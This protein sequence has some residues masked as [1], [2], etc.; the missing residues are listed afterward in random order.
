MSEQPHSAPK[1][2]LFDKKS[3]HQGKTVPTDKTLDAARED[4]FPA[5][6]PP[7]ITPGGKSHDQPE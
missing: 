3:D 2:G 6:N 1:R 7:D 5:S 4:S